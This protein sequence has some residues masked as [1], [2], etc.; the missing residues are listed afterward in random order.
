MNKIKVMIVD[1]HAITRMG[2]SSLLKTQRDFD[3]V[4]DAENGE[5]ALALAKKLKPDLVIMDLMMPGMDGAESTRRLVSEIPGIK[6][7][8]LTTFGTANS[9]SV[10]LAA[11]AHGAL[12]KTVK[13]PELC[14]AIRGIADGKIVISEET[15][16]ILDNSPSVPELSP[17]QHEILLFVTKGLTNEAIAQ[18]LGIG[19]SSVREHLQLACA[20]LGAAN[21]AEAVA[22]SL[23]KHLLKI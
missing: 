11:G 18:K 12:L 22:I 20:K 14:S 17:R 13:L 16:Q 19:L 5:A 1:D 9:L 4:G 15:R 10:A 21:R 3:L 6:I 7:L 8:I 23:R 2:L